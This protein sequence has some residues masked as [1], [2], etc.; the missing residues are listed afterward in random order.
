VLVR[1][2][3][4]LGAARAYAE[5][6]LTYWLSPVSDPAVALALPFQALRRRHLW[7]GRTVVRGGT[8]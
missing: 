5:P 7:R 6:P 4:L 8:R 3:V 1:C 2:G